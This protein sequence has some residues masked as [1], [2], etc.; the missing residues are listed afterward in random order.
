[1][2]FTRV[3][4]GSGV[5][6]TWKYSGSQGGSTMTINATITQNKLTFTSTYQGQTGSIPIRISGNNIYA[7]TREYT[8]VLE[9]NTLTLIEENT[10]EYD[11]VN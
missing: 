6:G 7:T 8:Y 3:G 5:T 9:G 10:E 11:R 1:M 2:P 4:S